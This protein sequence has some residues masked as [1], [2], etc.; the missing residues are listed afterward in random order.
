MDQDR[1]DKN[2]PE[3]NPKLN[4]VELATKLGL[5]NPEE[6]AGQMKGYL[7]D[8]VTEEEAIKKM[9]KMNISSQSLI[10]KKETTIKNLELKL[11]GLVKD[12]AKARTSL[13]DVSDESVEGEADAN[14]G[15]DKK[16]DTKEK[17]DKTLEKLE[18]LREQ[19][20][21]KLTEAE[22][23]ESRSMQ[24]YQVIDN[25]LRIEQIKNGSRNMRE[26]L[27]ME[28]AL[29]LL[30]PDNPGESPMGQFLFPH[31]I[32]DNPSLKEWAEVRSELAWNEDDPVVAAMRFIPGCEDDLK[33]MVSE[34]PP[35]SESSGRVHLGKVTSAD[36]FRKEIAKDIGRE[37]LLQKV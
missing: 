4:L 16:D 1:Q 31:T 36:E 35:E 37:D 19:Y 2:A 21:K 22:K 23:H 13:E 32:K 25:R 7:P 10:G 15:Q 26:R 5:E 18:Q 29:E 34:Q 20:E 6:A 11:E 24:K 30:N 12:S 28:R 14:K 9:A 17:T 3:K 33:E 27:G 8:D